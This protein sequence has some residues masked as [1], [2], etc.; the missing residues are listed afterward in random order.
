MTTTHMV[1]VDL[2]GRATLGKNRVVPGI[3]LLEIDGAGV[4]SLHPAHVVKS[5]QAKLD[6]RPG[7]MK[8]IDALSA[9]EKLAPSKR[10][11]PKRS[12]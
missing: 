7:L 2:R 12:S 1:E 3:Y 5:A 8:T 9:T 10:G 11:R 6:R 4:I